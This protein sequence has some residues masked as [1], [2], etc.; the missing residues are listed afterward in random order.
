MKCVPPPLI[1]IEFLISCVCTGE[2]EKG[3]G[4]EGLLRPRLQTISEKNISFGQMALLKTH[5]HFM[6]IAFVRSSGSLKRKTQVQK[7]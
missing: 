1:L 7:Q 4:G 3:R 6:I 2:E 5:D